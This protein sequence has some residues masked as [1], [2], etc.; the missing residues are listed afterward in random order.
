M[1]QS[2][3]TKKNRKYEQNE[4]DLSQQIDFQ[5]GKNGGWARGEYPP[6]VEVVPR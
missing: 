5:E 2:I 6:A 3:S 1:C 4:V